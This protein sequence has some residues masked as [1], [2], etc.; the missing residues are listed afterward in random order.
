[1]S[2]S[3]Q[4]SR[5][6]LRALD[7]LAFFAPDIQGGIGPFLV[8]FLS[9]TLAWSPDR[10]GTVMAASALVGLPLI[11]TCRMLREAGLRLLA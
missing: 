7:A 5:R 11:R 6:S 3:V 4:P 1:M 8:V 2:T 10:V 9:S